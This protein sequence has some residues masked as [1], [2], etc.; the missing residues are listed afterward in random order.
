M[1]EK[2]R[3]DDNTG[4]SEGKPGHGK[5]ILLRTFGCQM[6]VRDSEVVAGLLEKAGFEVCADEKAADVV[7]FNTCS[8][9]EHAENKVWSEIGRIVKG[10]RKDRRNKGSQGQSPSGSFPVARPLIGLVGCMAQNYKDEVF[11]KSPYV[12]FVVGPTDIDKIPSIVDRLLK[13]KSGR[14]G[15]DVY[16]LKVWETDAEVR[17]EHI[18]H[19]GHFG[20][21]KQAYVVISEG[22]SNFCSYCIVPYTRGPVR[23]RPHERILQ[24]IRE[25]VSGGIHD[26]TLLGQNVNSYLDGGFTFLDLL[27]AV[28]GIDGIEQFSFVTSHPRNASEGLFRTMAECDKLKKYLHLPVQAGSDRILAAMNRGYTRKYY[29]DLAAKYRTI[30]PDG[31]LTTDIIVGFPGETEQDFQDT[32]D[33]LGEVEFDAAFI[34]KYSPRPHT[35]AAQM[36]DDVATADKERR[37]AAVLTLQKEISSKR[38]HEKDRL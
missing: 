29:L 24:E 32:Y 5:R 26:I 25:A 13:H 36:A 2:E 8:V 22:C 34:F 12:D 17:P 6:N 9:R 38:K 28:N 21:P 18:Y 1:S 27:R 3:N 37:H 10:T 16:D 11:R 23:H 14:A 19:T 31:A 20:D 35:K 30:I 7:I 33:L 15:L 4:K